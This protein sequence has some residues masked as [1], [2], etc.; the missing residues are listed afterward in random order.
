MIE[1]T[2]MKIS[3]YKGKAVVERLLKAEDG[4]NVVLTDY[5]VRYDSGDIQKM[6]AEA[7]QEI[8]NWKDPVW[9]SGK[10]EESEKKLAFAI[11]LENVIK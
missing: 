3:S 6:I 9:I 2:K 7:K 11:E 5:T 10:L 1:K 8:Q 4:S